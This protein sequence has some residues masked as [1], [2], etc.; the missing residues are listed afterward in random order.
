MRAI[1]LCVILAQIGSFV[2][3]TEC[4]L[5]IHDAVL[6]RMGASDELAKGRSTFMVEAEEA[7][8]IMRVATSRSLVILDEIGRGTSTF[9]GQAIASAI[10]THLMT[11]ASRP[12][13]LFITHYTS[14][15]SLSERLPGV[16]NQHMGFIERKAGGSH[17]NGHSD[18]NIDDDNNDDPNAMRNEVVFLYR[19]QDGPASS[20]FGIHCAALAGLPP[21]L[22][23]VAERRARDLQVYTE[24]RTRGLR[25]RA[26]VAVL[27]RIAQG[28]R[29]QTQIEDAQALE[30]VRLAAG[31]LGLPLGHEDGDGEEG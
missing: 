7:A 20:S 4:R 26:A 6:T 17:A 21:E 22:L 13:T 25:A 27:R 30:E 31:R 29:T 3:A 2:P 12:S 15:C 19:L 10:L 24:E 16:R 18:H 11:R 14:L 9:D 28:E 23:S 1:A 5:S 8:E